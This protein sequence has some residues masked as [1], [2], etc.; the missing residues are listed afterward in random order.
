MRAS[1]VE[2]LLPVSE[3]RLIVELQELVGRSDHLIIDL[4][5]LIM[6]LQREAVRAGEVEVQ[7]AVHAAL[8]SIQ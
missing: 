3:A 2:E 7:L 1:R 6:H 4:T 8:R 5:T